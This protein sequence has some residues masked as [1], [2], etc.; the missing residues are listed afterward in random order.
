MTNS[1]LADP[2]VRVYDLACSDA[3]TVTKRNHIF[4]QIKDG[5]FHLLDDDTLFHPG[6]YRVYQRYAAQTFVGMVIGYQHN[7]DGFLFLRPRYP[8]H[9]LTTPT[10]SGMV[11]CYHSVL[12]FNRWV[13]HNDSPN[14]FNFWRRC[15]LY[16]GQPRT[17]L[18]T[19]VISYYNYFGPLI[20]VTKKFLFWR[21]SFDI[22]SFYVAWPYIKASQFLNIFRRLFGIKRKQD[23]RFP[24][25]A[26]IIGVIRTGI[27]IGEQ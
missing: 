7:R 27:R 3:D 18:I 11:L 1:F 6:M 10:D 4:D 12:N 25:P 2:R 5:Y 9:P 23:Q 20:R 14:D 16:L 13:S 8:M 15:Y 26:W 22:N 21:V 17:L 24:R 19:D